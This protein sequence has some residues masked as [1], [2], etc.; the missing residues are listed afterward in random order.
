MEKLA[1]DFLSLPP[2]YS[3]VCASSYKNL[4]NTKFMLFIY[5][6]RDLLGPQAIGGL[7]GRFNHE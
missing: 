2:C 7:H 4:R 5:S 3:F 1:K 6:Y